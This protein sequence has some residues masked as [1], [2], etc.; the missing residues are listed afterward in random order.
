[1]KQTFIRVFSMCLVMMIVLPMLF[2]CKKEKEAVTTEDTQT[3][4]VGVDTGSDE[5]GER[6]KYL[7]TRVDYSGEKFKIVLD[8]DDMKAK[9]QYMVP[10]DDASLASDAVNIALLNRN[11]LLEAFFGVDIEVS[12]L[13]GPERFNMLTELEINNMSGEDFADIFFTV[14]TYV[15]NGA[16][17]NGYVMDLNQMTQLNLEAS[18]YDQRIQEEYQI[19]GKLF[20]LE[21]DYTVYDEMRTQVV[22]INKTRYENFLY[23]ETYGSPYELVRDGKWT[24][25]TML[26]MTKG[27]SDYSNAGQ[28]SEMTKDSDWGIISESPFPY[29]VYLGT[30]NKIV[31]VN[32]GALSCS[33]ADPTKWQI[34]VDILSYC[35]ENIFDNPEVLI[36]DKSEGV[37]SSGYW[38]EAQQM[39][40]NGQALFRT[41]TLS[42]FIQYRAMED[43]FGILP[44]PKYSETQEG[45]YSWCSSMAHSPLMVPSTA[46]AHAE[47]TANII[48]AM[49]YFSKYMSGSTQSVLDAFYE[50]MTHVKLCR[51]AEDY[52]MLELIFSQKTFDLDYALNLSATGWKIGTFADQSSYSVNEAMS[53]YKDKMTSSDATIN[54][55]LKLLND[56][57]KHYK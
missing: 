13:D 57:W 48:E 19:E 34:T 6:S 17:S 20:T 2:A 24:I 1:M 27:T 47:R 40:A 45:Y 28:G 3:E 29:I 14:A 4:D 26:E 42:D 38:T 41:S 22:G 30:G 50:N 56:M 53:A 23:N 5:G 33:L 12:Y 9:A 16:I 7:P 31:N 35:T 51:S 11:K 15:M 10:V 21:G 25:E 52:E 18:Y 8:G 55:M 46:S 54:P 49:A 36:A 39:F 37:L 43:V 32:N 44:V